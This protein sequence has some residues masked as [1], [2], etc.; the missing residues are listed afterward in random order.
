[1]TVDKLKMHSPDLTQRNIDAIAELFPTVVTETLDSNGNPVRAVDF[2]LLRQELSDHIVEGPQER[3]QLDWPGKRAAAFAANAPIAKTL[4]PVRDESV[5]FDT[6]KN[7]F[8]EGDNLEALKLLQESY[9]GKVKLIYIDPPYNTGG[10]LIY[11]D[12]FAASTAEYLE[13]SGQ[14][15]ATGDRL[16]ANPDSNGRYHSDW[17]DMMYPRLKLARNL[18]AEDGVIFVSIDDAESANLQALL[19]EVFGRQNYLDTIVVEMSTTSGPKT[20]N[21]QQGTIVK[22][23]EFVHVY[24]RS[25]AFDLV[26]HTPLLDGIDDFDTHYS[27]WLNDDGTLASVGDQLLADAKVGADIRRLSLVSKSG[28]SVN[29]MDD[30]L[31]LSDAAKDFVNSN[32][33]RIAR[34]DRAPVSAHGRSTEVG[35]WEKFEADHRTYLLTTLQNGS[36]QAL[37]PLKLN[38]RMSDDY[39]PRF[40]RTVIRGDLWKGFYQDMGNVGKEG[41]LAFSNGKKPVRLIKQLMKWANNTKGGIV[42]DFFAGSGTTAHAVMEANAEDGGDRRFI[43]IQLDEVPDPKSEAAAAE[44]ATIAAFSRERLRRTVTQIGRGL[45]LESPSVDLGFRAMRVEST[46]MADVLVSPDA[47]DQSE[48][49]GTVAS[50]K[51]GRSGEDLLFQVL[52]DWGLEA[53]L[54]IERGSIDGRQIFAVAEDAL[55]AC[56]ADEVTDAVIQ[57]IATRHPLRAVFLDAGFAS[58]ASRINAEQIFREVSPQTEVRAI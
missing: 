57:E 12:D 1:M 34:I 24:K 45:N 39:K 22:N 21:A 27:V 4:R 30:L 54:P 17:L 7:L 52:L 40:G 50:V 26:R 42:L 13:K 35:R 6:T 47:A 25:A 37:I 5:D 28:F 46:N 2:D 36:L 29:K 55:I 23:A 49:F 8:I 31:A 16:V 19:D 33:S 32:L 58:D 11:E 41:G 56:F 20:V 53:G 51:P 10:D 18:L 15:S 43:L 44:F 9:L 38:Y 14:Q 3:Y 48:L